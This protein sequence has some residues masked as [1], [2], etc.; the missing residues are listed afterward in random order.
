MR[1]NLRILFFLAFCVF[2]SCSK[3]NQ[4]SENQV[5]PNVPDFVVLGQDDTELQLYSYSAANKQSTVTNLTQKSNITPEFIT[6]R[7]FKD[8]L[9]FYEFRDDSFSAKQ[10]NVS[11]GESKSIVNFY[12]TTPERSIIWGT[13][14]E[15]DIFLAFYSPDGS[16]NLNL[17]SININSDEVVEL[18][19][20]ND[21]QNTYQ[22]LLYEN[23]LFISYKSAAGNYHV[24]II[25]TD[26]NSVLSNLS[27]GDSR[28]SLLI[29]EKGDLVVIKSKTGFD[30]SYIVYDLET[31]EI[32]D[33]NTF[34]LNRFFAPGPLAA[35][36]SVD[37]LF[38]TNF[39]AQ[40]SEVNFAP[41]VFDFVS[42][43]NSVVDIFEIVRKIETEL[44]ES[45][46]LISRSFD[47]QSNTFFIGY[48]KRTLDNSF[49][50]GIL[51]IN[52]K[53]ELLEHIQ[54][55]FVPTYFVER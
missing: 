10:E 20:E 54:V 35:E 26:T 31:L 50:G 9:T 39:F 27:F 18:F 5:L 1:F 33:E 13:N 43:E 19:I 29:D 36:F 24:A 7:Q 42:G 40:P 12:T 44:G 51:I 11:T 28:A 4:D 47:M 21:V 49:A 15:T 53:G 46:V 16:S 32:V 23:R 55:P 38:Y 17:R 22:P 34:V 37:K 8:V 41:A 2:L 45:I 3:D 30:N 6:L 25:N 14:S 48:Q 52:P